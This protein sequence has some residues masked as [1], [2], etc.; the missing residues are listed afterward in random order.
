MRLQ[1]Y[2]FFV[3]ILIS[4]TSPKK[5]KI[6]VPE[7]HAGFYTE[8][9]DQLDDQLSSDPNNI[10]LIDQKLFYCEQLEWPHSCISALDVYKDRYGLSK[11]LIEQYIIYYKKHEDHQSLLD[12]IDEWDEEFSLKSAFNDTYISCLVKLNKQKEAKMELRKFLVKNQSKEDLSFASIQYLKMQDSLMAAYNLSKLYKKEPDNQLMWEYGIILIQLGYVNRGFGVME[13]Y[14]EEHKEDEAVQLTLAILLEQH[15]KREQARQMLL[16][17][18]SRD[19]ISYLLSE[20]Y[21]KDLLWDSAAYILNKVAN[22]DTLN[23]KPIWLLGS[24]YEDR[25][26][27]SRSKQYFQLL[28]DKNPNDSLAAQKVDLIQR[29]IAYLQRLKFEESKISVIELEPIKN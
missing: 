13:S 23:R 14:V 11:Q 4:C 19:T 6:V 20:W 18:V 25:G 8:A 24:L 5:D 9:L 22:E 10:S 1:F 27:L 16:P 21:R 3:P 17:F 29:K 2:L 28:V 15:E 7:L 26:W 12:L